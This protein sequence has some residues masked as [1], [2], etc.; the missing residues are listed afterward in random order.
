MPPFGSV[1]D[2]SR[3][4]SYVGTQIKWHSVRD[5]EDRGSQGP[6]RMV[7]NIK[8]VV[9]LLLENQSFDRVVGCFR[10]L[11]PTLEG[12][13]APGQ[14]PYRNIDDK[15]VV[16]EQKPTVTKQ[17]T[18]DPKHEAR[19]VLNQ[20]K[21][22]N[23]E[24]VLDFVQNY[25]S[26]T[27]QQRQEIMGYYELG[28]LPALHTLAREFTIC[29]HWFSSLPGPTWP[30]RFFALTGTCNGQALMPEG[31]K[32]P[33]LETY[34]DQSQN[35]IFDRLN[36]RHIA[37]KVYYYDFPSSLLLTHQRRPENLV[38]Y[39]RID[40]FYEDCAKESTFPEFVFV[41]PKYFGADQND[42]HP[43]HNIFKGEKLI[44]DVYNG[45]R[46]NAELWDSTLLVVTFDEH[47]GFFDHVVPP[48]ANPPDDIV[49]RIDPEDPSAVFHFDRYGV[50][51]PAILVSPWVA[52]GV[53]NTVF[54]HASLLKY[55]V[56]KWGLEELGN[57][58]ATVNS[59]SVAIKNERLDNTPRFIRV[60]Y[61]D[62]IP[63]D[64]AL[65]LEDVSEHH[66]ALEA[67]AYHLA[68]TTGNMAVVQHAM[69]EP[70]LWMRFKAALGKQMLSVGAALASD[71]QRF[72]K[73]KVDKTMEFVNS[74]VDKARA[75]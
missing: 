30:N 14:P 60:P 10:E 28:F 24:F 41:E 25:P 40:T 34:V 61:T 59:I 49:A 57:R 9:F 52:K 58:T 13:N 7:D 27:P 29:D 35:T 3:R 44:A 70:Q 62:L 46:S 18:P 50:R 48:P 6:N 5:I 45:I 55:M 33:Q 63:P 12:L 73:S 53:E 47:G 4:M 26:S 66:K 20:L 68:K 1:T 23:A 67:F 38:H 71:L 11:Y 74:L 69:A 43:P 16:Y 21:N 31:W 17:V 32:D 2:G 75:G 39:H 56:E 22:N 19:F 36:Q 72:R 65:E 51:V 64:P 37:W 54:D 8:H 15:G 42:D